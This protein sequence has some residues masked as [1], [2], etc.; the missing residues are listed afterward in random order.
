MSK[1]EEHKQ[2]LSDLRKAL[3]FL[4]EKEKHA[5][6]NLR[7]SFNLHNLTIENDTQKMTCPSGLENYFIKV[8]KKDFLNIFNTACQLMKEGITD[9]HDEVEGELVKELTDLAIL[10][11]ELKS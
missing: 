5:V 4:Q 3:V 6:I 7:A 2:R 9:K 10:N 1:I 8:I 11:K